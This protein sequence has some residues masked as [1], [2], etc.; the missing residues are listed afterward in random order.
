MVIWTSKNDPTLS[1]RTFLRGLGAVVALPW[2]D[3]MGGRT[4]RAQTLTPPVRLMYFYLPNGV[5]LEGWKPAQTGTEFTLP[6]ILQPLA[7]YQG[8]LN[9]LSGLSNINGV[10][11]EA[12]D[13][14]AGTGAF[15]TC[16]KVKK[17]EG[18]DIEN[19][20]SVDQVAANHLG[21]DTVLPSLEVGLDPG[22]SVGGCDSGYSC[23]YINNISWS[24]PKTPVAK[25][26]NPAVVFDRLFGG[27]GASMTPEEQQRRKAQRLSIADAVW[28]QAK[29]L[30]GKLGVSDGL[31]LEEY[32]YGVN[33]LEKRIEAG[34]TGACEAPGEP[35]GPW[36]IETKAQVMNELMAIA[37]QCDLTRFGSYMMGKGGSNISFDFIGVPGQH[38]ELSHH[39]SDPDKI[40]ALT[41]ICTWEM[42]QF[43]HFLELLNSAQES[44]GTVLDNSL[45]FISSEIQNGNSHTHYNLPVVVAGKGGGVVATGQHRQYA[46]AYQSPISNL[47]LTMLNVAGHPAQSFA[48]STGLLDLS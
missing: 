17:T 43:A 29:T 31:K 14:A 26:T 2:L 35:Q 36:T 24:G 38:H 16:T 33:E 10:P 1:R 30:Q 7:P 40:A 19:G 47:F 18:A 9:V 4:A 23:A 32:L 20:I 41:T 27:A 45:V 37:L 44:N 21:G 39:D 22:P 34:V 6:P 15:L 25:S 11:V 5:P 12:G 13:H 3:I 48:D 46:E 8:S 42:T 28:S